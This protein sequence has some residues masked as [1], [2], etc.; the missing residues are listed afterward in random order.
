MDRC[1]AGRL[2]HVC[3][4]EETAF[5]RHVLGT[6]RWVLLSALLGLGLEL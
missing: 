2:P 6:C 4:V 5:G 1:A 3:H